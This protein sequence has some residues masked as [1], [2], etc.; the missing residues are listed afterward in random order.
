VGLHRLFSLDHHNPFGMPVPMPPTSN[1]LTASAPSG[2]AGDNSSMS[3]PRQGSVAHLPR[4]MY[5]TLPHL[6]D[7]A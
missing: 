4:R 6:A 3:T 5:V 2:P 1:A 7:G